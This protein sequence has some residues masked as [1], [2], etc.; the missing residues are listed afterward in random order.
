MT[1]AE[2]WLGQVVKQ[3]CTAGGGE[4]RSGERQRYHGTLYPSIASTLT[5]HSHII[6]FGR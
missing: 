5:Q 4:N 1:M 3:I 6:V 2:R